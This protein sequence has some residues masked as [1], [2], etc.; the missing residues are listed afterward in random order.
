MPVGSF[1]YGYVNTPNKWGL[2]TGSGARSQSFHIDFNAQFSDPPTV[3]VSLCGLDAGNQANLRVTLTPTN[4]T[5]T[6]FDLSIGTWG[7]SVIYTVW[8]S[9]YAEDK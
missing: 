2:N 1:L 6:G 5:A 7:D 4:I 3:I 8:G 9:W